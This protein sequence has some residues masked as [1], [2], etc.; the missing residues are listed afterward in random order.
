MQ[1]NGCHCITIQVHVTAPSC[2][3]YSNITLRSI[4]VTS[5]RIPSLDFLSYCSEFIAQDMVA[6]LAFNIG[7][8]YLQ[9]QT[10]S[11]CTNLFKYRFKIIALSAGVV[12][13]ILLLIT[14]NKYF[15]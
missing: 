12:G 2:L 9:A 15:P 5:Y 6:N 8:S 13:F 10:P 14:Y 1:F 4:V 11:L 7:H 3:R